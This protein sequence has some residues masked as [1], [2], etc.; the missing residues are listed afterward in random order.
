MCLITFAWRVDARTPLLLA[1]NRDEF[2][3]RPPAR[4]AW[5][6]ASPELFVGRGLSHGGR[7]L[8]LVGNSLPSYGSRLK[9]A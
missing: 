9:P 7:W 1:V 8:A 3:A 5:L 4:A 2:H 6:N